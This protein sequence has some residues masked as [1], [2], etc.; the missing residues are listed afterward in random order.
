VYDE[1]YFTMKKFVSI[2]VTLAGF[3]FMAN[4]AVMAGKFDAKI[5]MS[6]GTATTYYVQG[7]FGNLEATDF[8]VDTGSGFLTINKPTLDEL[9]ERGLATYKRDLPG[10][11]A[12]GTEIEVPVYQVA[13]FSIGPCLLQNVEAAVFPSTKRQILGLNVL[14]RSAPFIFSVNP[15]ELVLSHC[16]EEGLADAEVSSLAN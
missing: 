9:L 11:M 15:P 12:D 4:A 3:L 5:P 1:G 2:P 14:N 13:Q 6:V 16:T 7:R 10:V 8:M